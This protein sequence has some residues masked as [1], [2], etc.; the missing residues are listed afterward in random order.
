MTDGFKRLANKVTDFGDRWER[1]AKDHRVFLFFHQLRH[2]ADDINKIHDSLRRYA[3]H[4]DKRLT[5]KYKLTKIA[6]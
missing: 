4:H 6:E 2:Y 1:T 3:I 5:S